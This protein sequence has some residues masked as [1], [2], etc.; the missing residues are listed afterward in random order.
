MESFPHPICLPE[1]HINNLPRFR[2]NMMLEIV[3]IRVSRRAHEFCVILAWRIRLH[4]E[5][6]AVA[7][8]QRLFVSGRERIIMRA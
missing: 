3:T 5:D 6:E 1:V 2:M 7:I 4:F 8:V